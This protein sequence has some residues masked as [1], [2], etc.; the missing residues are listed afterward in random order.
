M[1]R[2][3]LDEGG[4]RRAAEDDG[5]VDLGGVGDEAL[6][7]D[8]RPA[9]MADPFVCCAEESACEGTGQRARVEGA[10][11]KIGSGMSWRVYWG[12]ADAQ[13]ST[14]H[15]LQ[16]CA[17][18]GPFRSRRRG[19]MVCVCKRCD[20]Q[21]GNWNAGKRMWRA[22]PP[23][24]S[25]YLEGAEH[26]TARGSMGRRCS[27]PAGAGGT[28][29]ETLLRR[30]PRRPIPDMPRV[31]SWG[32]EERSILAPQAPTRPSHTSRTQSRWSCISISLYRRWS[33]KHGRL[34]RRRGC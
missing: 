6:D 30:P 23:R 3:L 14:V 4:D 21:G 18:S 19:R 20:D 16:H 5:D 32:T 9:E 24:E 10:S 22:R 28:G 25:S 27:V 29:V 11:S 26:R 7:D 17:E 15:V 1:P 31:P 34:R 33:C 13:V 2:E 12:V 8:R